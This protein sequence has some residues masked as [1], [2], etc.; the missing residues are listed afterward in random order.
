M[1]CALRVRV[2]VFVSHLFA[3]EWP[4][5]SA[6]ASGEK[7][8]EARSKEL[9]KDAEDRPFFETCWDLL[10]AQHPSTLIFDRCLFAVSL[11]FQYAHH[12]SPLPIG[13]IRVVSIDRLYKTHVLMTP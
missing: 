1:T 2:S 7:R 8:E 11:S 6:H 9:F 13:H 12:D 5:A 4:L 3:S 10:P